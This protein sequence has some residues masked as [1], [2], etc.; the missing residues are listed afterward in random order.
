MK[1][2]DRKK[3]ETARKGGGRE[4]ERVEKKEEKKRKGGKDGWKSE[5]YEDTADI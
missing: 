1:K 4:R 2:R 5:S 3:G